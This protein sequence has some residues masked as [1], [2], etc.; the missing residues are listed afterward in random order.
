M[1]AGKALI[2]DGIFSTGLQGQGIGL[3]TGDASER[4]SAALSALWA[5]SRV[6][7]VRRRRRDAGSR[8]P[9]LFQAR[10]RATMSSPPREAASG[11]PTPDCGA[12]SDAKTESTP[13]QAV[14]ACARELDRTL[15]EHLVLKKPLGHV[16]VAAY[17][18]RDALRRYDAA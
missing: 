7:Q 2:S 5:R 9:L 8:V 10:E 3:P 6:G 13:G 1:E 18:L 16:V 14:I 15:A 12:G 17:A 11:N 4:R